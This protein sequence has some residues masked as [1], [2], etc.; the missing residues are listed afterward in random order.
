MPEAE[1]P[2]QRGRTRTAVVILAAGRAARMGRPKT[3]LVVAGRTLL[4]HAI[5]TALASAAGEVV[6]VLRPGDSA[7]REAVGRR[8][9]AR[10]RAVRAEDADRGQ[11]RSLAAGL[12][13]LAHDVE[14]A[15]VLLSDQPGLPA[16][17]VDR[18]LEAAAASP[19]PAVRPV[20]VEGGTR[21]PGHPVVLKRALFPAARALAGDE[22]ARA[23]WRDDP[24]LLEEVLVAGTAPPDVDTPEDYAR[25]TEPTRAD[26]A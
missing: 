14:A 12:D 19:R 10:L 1:R 7:G 5:D 15:A 16:G 11:G 21:V 24:T 8:G 3:A 9:T 23:L 26:P 2:G 17:L 22:G 6:V 20:F 25:L 18:I 13:A 4:D